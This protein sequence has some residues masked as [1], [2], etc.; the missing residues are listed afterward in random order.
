M[1]PTQTQVER[2]LAAL[3]HTAPVTHRGGLSAAAA[4][5]DDVPVGLI[6]ALTTADPVRDDRVAEAQARLSGGATPTDDE[7]AGRMVG[8]L[9]CDR[10]R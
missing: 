9:V 5:I 7:L 4:T 8:R 10:L 6:D 1:Q 2:T 3:A